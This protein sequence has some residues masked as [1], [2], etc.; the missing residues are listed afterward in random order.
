MDTLEKQPENF[1]S[2]QFG[3]LKNDLIWRLETNTNNLFYVYVMTEFQSPVFEHMVR[4]IHQYDGD[5]KMAL[6]DEGLITSHT[7]Y[8]CDFGKCRD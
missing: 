1:I 5:F 6:L 8:P 7:P 4:R 2:S 3:G